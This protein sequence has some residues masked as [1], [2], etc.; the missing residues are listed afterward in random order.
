MRYPL[1][2]IPVIPNGI[3]LPELDPNQRTL[4]RAKLGI[5]SDRFLIGYVAR[6]AANKGQ[7]LMLKVFKLLNQEYANRITLIYIGDGPFREAVSQQVLSEGLSEQIKFL[8]IVNPIADYYPLFDCTALLSDYEGMPNVVIE[9]MSFALPVVANPVGNVEELF[10]SGGGIVNKDV[11]PEK[12][13]EHFIHLIGN[14]AFANSTGQE[15]RNFIHREFS[16]EHTLALLT[17]H[18]AS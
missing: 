17:K 3:V 18:Y 8:G 15:A 4:M 14:P 9:A 11:K 13:A 12:I 16:I 2:K 6:F 5:D 7:S 1:A 10:S